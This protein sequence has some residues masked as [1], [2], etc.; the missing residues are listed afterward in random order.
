MPATPLPT[1]E[2]FEAQFPSLY[3]DFGLDGIVLYEREGYMQRKLARI[4]EIIQE[5]GLFRE[6]L[7]PDCILLTGTNCGFGLTL[8]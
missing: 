3:L 4:C 7:S 1:P 6:R 2:E 8:L 5:A